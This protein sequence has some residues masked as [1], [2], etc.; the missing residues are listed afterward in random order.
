M[1]DRLTKPDADESKN[2][3]FYFNLY[4]NLRHYFW[5]CR[6]SKAL[7]FGYLLYQSIVLL[8]FLWEKD[9]SSDQ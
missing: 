7:L 9:V 3:E 6:E 1:F 4:K 2:R 5:Q 8:S